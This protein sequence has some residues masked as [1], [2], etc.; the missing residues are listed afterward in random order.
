[1][2]ARETAVGMRAAEAE[3]SGAGMRTKPARRPNPWL[4]G[5][6]AVA[7]PAIAVAERLAWPDAPPAIGVEWHLAAVLSVWA[8]LVAWQRHPGYRSGK[9][10]VVFGLL[11]FQKMLVFSGNSILFTLGRSWGDIWFLPIVYL[12]LAF[13]TGKL[14]TRAQGLVFWPFAVAYY[15]IYNL[16]VFGLLSPRSEPFW[17]AHELFSIHPVDTSAWGPYD[18]FAHTL[19]V[20]AIVALAVARWWKA[21]PPARRVLA[22][23]LL[24]AIVIAIDV[25]AV[26][27]I[28]TVIGMFGLSAEEFTPL[29]ILLY[30]VG[31]SSFLAVPVGVLLGLYLARRAQARVSRLV[32]ELDQLPGLGALEPSLRRTLRDP[33]LRVGLYDPASG[34]YRT[35]DGRPFEVLEE[36]SNLVAT[37]LERAGKPLGLMV[38]DKALLEN[39]HLMESTAAAVRMAVDNERLHRAVRD[40]LEEVRASRARIVE[41]S[42]AERRRVERN[43]HDGA[44]Q[45]LVS[46]AMSLRMARARAEAAGDTAL[47]AELDR[48][49]DDLDRA[50]AELRD[51]AQ[52]IHP[53]VLTEE[54]LAAALEDLAER[55]PV[56][57]T[58]SIPQARYPAA[59]EA[60]AYFVASEALANVAK[61]SRAS[62]ARVRVSSEDETLI[63]EIAD[64]GVGGA[65]LSKGS[66]LRGLDDRLAALGGSFRVQRAAHGGTR[67]VAEIPCEADRRR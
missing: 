14:T 56:R 10:M 58:L 16:L 46:L 17:P 44:Q 48:S 18:T 61:H 63:V 66:G 45:R 31:T 7:A 40:Q 43:L 50:I 52:G 35:A 67:V 6:L 24:P 15:F 23:A 8:G 11:L 19:W 47:S 54:G 3:R 1:M 27:V 32:V 49:S 42:D 25:K 53:A 62:A 64:D 55:S 28:G 4:L 29:V 65:D 59:V 60:T 22:P 20:T 26:D 38:H 36:A 41:A 21:S 57:V 2:K 51:L 13:P 37:R 5:A 30:R 12:T 39:P 9:I 33:A 34:T